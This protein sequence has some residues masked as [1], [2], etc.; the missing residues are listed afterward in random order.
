MYTNIG[1][2]VPE[3]VIGGGNDFKLPT[4]EKWLGYFLEDIYRLFD[5]LNH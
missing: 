2:G 4:I 1:T 5:V 3:V